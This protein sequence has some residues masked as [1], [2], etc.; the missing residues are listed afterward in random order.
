M[1]RTSIAIGIALVGIGVAACTPAQQS[2][3]SFTPPS[4]GDFDPSMPSS[5]EEV[6]YGRLGSSAF[7]SDFADKGV[8]FEAMFIGEGGYIGI[9]EKMGVWTR[10]RVFINHRSVSYAETDTGLAGVGSDIALPLSC[11]R[12]TGN[13]VTLCTNSSAAI[14]SG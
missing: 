12:S 2:L 10:D 9:Y 3:G 13:R 11:F 7:A 6:Q 14:S 8:T 1:N 5:F 4:A